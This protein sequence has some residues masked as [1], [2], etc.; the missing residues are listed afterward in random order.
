MCRSKSR[1]CMACNTGHTSR[2]VDGEPVALTGG[3]W[4]PVRGVLRWV[5][6][7]IEEPAIQAVPP[8]ACRRCGARA[9][10]T[11]RSRNGH[12][13]GSH[14]ERHIPRRCACGGEVGWKQRHCDDCVSSYRR[15]VAA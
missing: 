2:Y 5:A 13:T 12:R 7:P 8:I 9:D 11:C 6:D 3:S 15:N 10:Q 4:Q 1:V 14:R